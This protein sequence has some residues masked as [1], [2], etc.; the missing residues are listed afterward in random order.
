VASYDANEAEVGF[1]KDLLHGETI[2]KKAANLA[3]DTADFLGVKT[4]SPQILK[5]LE[6][7]A[8][9]GEPSEQEPLPA[10]P[11]GQNPPA[12]KAEAKTPVEAP[13]RVE[14][15]PAEEAPVEAVKAV[16]VGSAEPTDAEP[17]P[18]PEPAAEPELPGR[19]T[20]GKLFT[21]RRA[22]PL[23]IFDVL[24]MRYKQAWPEWEPDTL[25]WALRR[26]FG[27]VGEIARNKIQALTFAASTDT[28][29][30]DFDS[31]ENCGQA[32][33]DFLPIFGAFQPLTPM[34][35]AFAVQ[36]LRGIRPEDEF[37]HEVNAYIAAVLDEH[38]WVYAP[39]EWFAGAQAI[40]D[41]KDW[42]VG[43]KADVAQAW[44]HIKDIPAQ[45]IEWE[46]DDARSIHLLKLA[47]VK[48]Y[49]DGRAEL[50]DVVPGVPASSVTASPPVP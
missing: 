46:G 48:S 24:I 44:K 19:E 5:D 47:V 28:P 21:N 2:E 13:P 34:Q 11:K 33:N 50:R 37:G 16:D 17:E 25:W 23:Q 6:A 42:L 1:F 27:P 20:H 14:E 41:R 29:W 26:D 43:L 12:Q 4:V 30:L 9:E 18:E 31:F 3:P 10:R 40:L 45:E 39:E 22:H 49:L 36:V 35:V 32:W 38:G 15:A 7:Q 8:G